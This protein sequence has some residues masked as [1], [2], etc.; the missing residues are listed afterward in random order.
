MRHSHIAKILIVDDEKAG[1]T[2]LRNTLSDQGFEAAGCTSGL[3]ALAS[4]KSGDFDLL[5]T[6]LMMPE[7]DGIA[8][9][10]Q[11]FEIDPNLV[12]IIM[13]GA[14]TIGTAVEAMKAGAFDYVLKPIKLSVLV[15]VLSR[16]LEVRRLCRDNVQL[17]GLVDIYELSVAIALTLDFDTVLQKAADAAIS[18]AEVGEVTILL[19]TGDGKEFYV[20]ALRGEN[21]AIM[22][23][24]RMSIGEGLADWMSRSREVIAGNDAAD[25]DLRAVTEH[26]FRGVL[27]GMLIP[28]MTGGKLVGVM[29]LNAARRQ[30]AFTLGQ[31]KSLG[32]LASTAASALQASLLYAQLRTAEQRFRRLA[33]NAQDA[34]YRYEFVPQQRMSYVNPAV[35]ALTGYTPEDF[36]ADPELVLKIVHPDDRE[37]LEILD[38]DR[39]KEQKA[40][41]MR[42]IRKD[43]SVVWIEPRRVP[44]FDAAGK[45]IAIEGIAH[46]ITDARGYQYQLEH[47]ATHDMLTNLANRNLLNDRLQQAIAHA[48]RNNQLVA[49]GYID[50]DNFKFINDS[51]GHSAGDRLLVEMTGRLKQCV[52]DGDTLARMAGD[53][54]VIV[55]TEAGSTSRVM[56]L[57]QRIVEC[58]AAPCAL[59]GHTLQTTCSLGLSIYPSDGEDAETLLRHADIAMHRVK[60]SG[61]NDVQFFIQEMNARVEDKLALE[62]ALRH[63][64]GRQEFMLHYQPQV[65]LKSG[66]VTALE[67]LIR[68]RH[69]ALGTILP[70]RFIPLAEE[71]GLIIP[72]GEWVL[73]TACAQAKAWHDAGLSSVAISVNLS[74]RQFRQRGL[75]KRVAETLAETGLTA[76]YLELELTESLVMVD[77]DEAIDTLR[78]LR[79]MGVSVAIDDFGTG[80]SSLTYLKRF[81]LD[82]LK[83]D[84]SFV[85][86]LTV[87]AGS[88]GIA[89]TVVSLAHVLNLKVVAEGV[90]TAEQLAFLRQTGCDEIQGYH[91][92]QP[93]TAADCTRLLAE[94]RR[95]S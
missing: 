90:E 66:A 34:I 12:G 82:R 57:M 7:M 86:D 2:A 39:W 65:D 4:L 56:S 9:L 59:N 73:L 20:A 5:L 19:P 11:A 63:A 79:A 88:A 30:R 62:S 85:Q 55:L 21:P 10:R 58:V 36:Y 70:A 17:R 43:G 31:M 29:H 14:G 6:D 94:K 18:V 68:W 89:R 53:E 80:H 33:E 92:S 27:P 69:P 84:R 28:M 49:V 87:D 52:R 13:T 72:I 46:D 54:F 67:A 78:E 95:L 3:E 76:K 22:L 51:L 81:P 24:Q 32:I 93:L 41:A 83:I 77:I 91:F 38:L 40:V 23:G 60:E 61:G 16:A 15:P 75:A 35:S 64:L 44:V 74:A 26:P 50:L 1:M 47:Q 37:A 25:G 42:W 71:T 45:V 48:Q 8:L